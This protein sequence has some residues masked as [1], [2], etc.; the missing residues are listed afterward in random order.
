MHASWA[1]AAVG[2]EHSRE[3]LAVRERRRVRRDTTVSVVLGAYEL[4]QGSSLDVWSTSSIPTSTTRLSQKSST[5]T[6]AIRSVWSMTRPPVACRTTTTNSRPRSDAG[7]RDA[8][9]AEDCHHLQLA[10]E[11]AHVCTQLLQ[12]RHLLATLELAYRRL[13]G[14]G[15][16]SVSTCESPTRSRSSRSVKTSSSRSAAARLR[17]MRSGDI[18]SDLI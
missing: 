7:K 10:A 16:L 1:A 4:E 9:V 3:A 2:C 13:R 12:A 14:L 5:K 17:L 6:N 11:R 8:F 15:Q 18:V